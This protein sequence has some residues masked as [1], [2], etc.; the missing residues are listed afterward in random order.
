MASKKEEQH[1]LYMMKKDGNA[2]SRAELIPADEVEDKRAAG[3]VE[4]IGQK[5][6]GAKWNDEGDLAA[7]DAAAELA[8]VGAERKAEKDKKKAD[9]REKARKEAEANAVP[10]QEHP[11][12]RVEVVEQPKASKKK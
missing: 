8:K 4:P 7:Q 11:D 5:A 9:E 10:P 3:Y 6:N 2:Y 12:L 1:A